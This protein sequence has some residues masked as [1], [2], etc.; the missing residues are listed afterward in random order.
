MMR[1]KA[2]LLGCGV[3]GGPLFVLVFLAQDLTRPHFN[4]VR[5][6]VSSLANGE[7]GWVQTVNFLVVGLLT[8]TF[9]I[10][11]RQALGPGKA[12]FAGSVLVGFW[13]LGAFVA[14]L[15]ATDPDGS[16]HPS[17]T[18]LLHNL[19]VQIGFPAFALACAVFVRVFAKRGDRRWAVGTAVT[20]VAFA[21]AA[22]LAF[23]GFGHADG[24][25]VTA[26]LF[27]RV[28]AVIAFSW[29]VA[30]AVRLRRV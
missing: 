2:D 3:F 16:A 25:G 8:M 18:G 4:P 13:G 27:E 5:N 28:T 6:S 22:E 24:L 20:G 9:A 12:V 26:G 30:L 23:R 19:A 15:F 14:G 7:L 17:T 10:G 1:T 11:L 21:A 29:I